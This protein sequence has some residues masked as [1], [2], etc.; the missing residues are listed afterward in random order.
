MTVAT[1]A[2][3]AKADKGAAAAQPSPLHQLAR[4]GDA[5]GVA[6]AV[7]ADPECVAAVDSLQ[8]TALHLA[9]WAGHADV[10]RLLLEAKAN[11]HAGACDNMLALHFA[12]QNGH[13]AVCK[14]LL[15][16][17]GKVNAADAK[18]ANTALHAASKNH[19]AT[20]YL[21][22]K[23]GNVKARNK[24]GKGPRARTTDE[25]RQLF[26]EAAGRRQAPKRRR[27]RRRHRGGGRGWRPGRSRGAA[28]EPGRSRW[29]SAGAAARPAQSSL[30]PPRLA[31]MAPPQ[32]AGWRRRT[33][34]GGRRR[35]LGGWRRHSWGAA[36]PPS[37]PRNEP[38]QPRQAGPSSRG[39][40]SHRRAQMMTRSEGG[41]GLGMSGGA[42]RTTGTPTAPGVRVGGWWGGVG[43]E[44]LGMI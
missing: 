43:G 32:L 42:T 35:N 5:E 41:V 8:R 40:E 21:L 2:P 20:P 4:S 26:A 17:G 31:G 29:P 16:G 39:T 11:V 22:K 10:V 9:A 15:K 24:A 37:P 14:E 34:G 13:E 12:A 30:P 23:N 19:V 1:M 7:A 27:R 44:S 3:K 18:R 25:V 28:F 6:A 36:P 38:L 33:L